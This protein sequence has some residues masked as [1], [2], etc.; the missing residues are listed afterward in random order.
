MYQ[1]ALARGGPRPCQTQL[2]RTLTKIR[3][4]VVRHSQD[5][6]RFKEAEAEPEPEPELEPE[7]EPE[8]EPEL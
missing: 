8:P 5:L 6:S 7:L 2:A 4:E 3:T 1:T